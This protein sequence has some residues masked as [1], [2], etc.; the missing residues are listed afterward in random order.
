MH[1]TRWQTDGCAQGGAVLHGLR[2]SAFFVRFL[3]HLANEHEPRLNKRM[4]KGLGDAV[5]THRG[6]LVLSLGSE[7]IQRAGDQ[8]ANHQ[9]DADPVSSLDCHGANVS[10]GQ[11]RF[12]L[13]TKEKK[14]KLIN[15]LMSNDCPLERHF[16]VS[17]LTEIVHP[18]HLSHV[19]LVW[20]L[21]SSIVL[22]MY[23]Y[24]SL[25]CSSA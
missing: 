11:S 9:E 17:T 14:K 22:F 18:P 24:L 25:R 8:H 15:D 12:T 3:T 1:A 5:G 16:R 13:N 6:G 19:S 4:R 21:Q 7:R 23:V 10:Q 20:R 2:F